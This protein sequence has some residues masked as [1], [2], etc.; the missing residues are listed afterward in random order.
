MHRGQICEVENTYRI[1]FIFYTYILFFYTSKLC[2]KKILEIFM[3]ISNDMTK[4]VLQS[5]GRSEQNYELLT[6][7]SAGL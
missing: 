4:D 1:T 6:D 3:R 2:L 5:Y 7:Y